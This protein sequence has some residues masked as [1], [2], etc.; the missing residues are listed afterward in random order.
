MKRTRERRFKRWLLLPATF[1]A[2]YGVFV[3]YDVCSGNYAD[4]MRSP[5]EVLIPENYVGYVRIDYG[6]KK[7]P[8]LPTKQGAQICAVPPSGYLR[9]ST[10]LRDGWFREEFYYVTD[11]TKTLLTDDDSDNAQ[12][13][14]DG[15]G[16]VGGGNGF[17][18]N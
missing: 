13:W 5:D 6:F 14:D 15:N 16:I 2:V 17:P 1:V 11:R 12:I 18:A 7:A 9:T 4:A 3:I 8:A 10:A